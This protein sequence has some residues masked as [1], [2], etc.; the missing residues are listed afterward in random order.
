MVVIVCPCCC[1]V[2][3]AA[4]VPWQSVVVHFV[5]NLSSTKRSKRDNSHHH[6][7]IIHPFL[8]LMAEK[9]VPR[10]A[11]LATVAAAVAEITSSHLLLLPRP[12][13]HLPSLILPLLFLLPPVLF[14]SPGKLIYWIQTQ[15][16]QLGV[17]TSERPRVDHNRL[18]QSY[19]CLAYVHPSLYFNHSSYRLSLRAQVQLQV[20]TL[21]ID[22]KGTSTVHPWQWITW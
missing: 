13:K 21:T 17:N 11:F 9:K 4:V 6:Q 19:L 20:V 10:R 15:L 18:H 16:Q 5:F 3:P 1:L 2:T 14:M 8:C 22:S 12:L 7:D